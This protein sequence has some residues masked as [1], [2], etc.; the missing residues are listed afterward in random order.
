MRF[1]YPDTPPLP[2]P[3]GHRFP[4]HKYQL[5]LEHVRSGSLIGPAWIKA[6]PRA[7][8]EALQR[9]HAPGYINDV[10]A[11]TLDAPAQKRIGVPWSPVLKD[12]ALATVG[13]TVAAAFAAL[14]EGLSGQLAGGTHHAHYDFG[15]GFCVFNDVAVAIDQLRQSSPGIRCAVL[16]LD[17]HQGDGNAALLAGGKDPQT[18]VASVHGARNY[19]FEK[20]PSDLDIALPDATEDPD[21]M[22]AV[23]TAIDAISAFKPDLL[24]YIAGVD[25]LKA[26]RLGRLHVSMEGLFQ[27]DADVLGWTNTHNCPCV[28][29]IG[30]G[31]AEPIS[32]TVAAYAQTFSVA[33]DIYQFGDGQTQTWTG[34]ALSGLTSSDRPR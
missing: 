16:D 21:Y 31:Y 1:F 28:I 24:F 17:V 13:G 15:S 4:A 10:L 2:L 22:T 19:P 18:F 11:G 23:Q 3:P 9:V 5:L 27:R 32:Q 7:T 25:P 12:R 20:V 26:D 6:S 8:L 33:R 29:L 34:N 30:G 14:D